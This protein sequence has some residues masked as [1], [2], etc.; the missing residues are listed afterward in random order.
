MFPAANTTSSSSGG[1]TEV[2]WLT[3]AQ[4][5][6][7]IEAIETAMEHADNSKRITLATSTQLNRA[8]ATLC[9]LSNSL[10]VFDRGWKS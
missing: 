6:E 10:A 8:K 3:K 7:V 4:V 1:D 5:E 2:L 9:V